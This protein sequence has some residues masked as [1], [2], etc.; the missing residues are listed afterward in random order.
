MKTSA[1]FK[2]IKTM[3]KADLLLHLEGAVTPAVLKTLAG[4]Y[5]TEEEINLAP[6]NEGNPYNIN[7]QED[8]DGARQLIGRHLRKPKDYLLVLDEIHKSMAGQNIV[9]SEVFF[10][11]AAR[12]RLGLD[13]ENVL[14][15]LLEKSA[16]VEKNG[17]PVI[18]W[19]LNCQRNLGPDSARK[20]VDLA[21][22]YREQGVVAVG[23]G[24][25]VGTAESFDPDE[26]AKIFSWAKVQGLFIHVYT[27]ET[28]SPDEVRVAL[29]KLGANRIGHGIQAARDPQLMKYLKD[30][31]AGLDICL[32]GDA[33]TGVWKHTLSHPFSLLWKRGVPVSLCTDNPGILGCSLTDEMELAVNR[34]NLGIP[35]L[36]KLCMKSV[37]LSFLPYREKMALMQKIGDRISEIFTT[38]K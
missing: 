28:D 2:L 14:E 31:T 3:P 34:F 10:S 21:I 22:R 15:L 32:T 11:P 30:R 18:R 9:Y 20:T 4:K 12:W 37:S 13:A 17:G 24:S 19:I 23:L 5:S 35:D 27:G 33:R 26:Y 29:E 38:L 36:K 1:L 8:L 16:G 6:D 25:S 7:S